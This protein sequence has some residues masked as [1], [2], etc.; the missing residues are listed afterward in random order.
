MEERADSS[1]TP[2]TRYVYSPVYIDAIITITRDSD[3]NGSLDQRL[4]VVQ[5]SNW[6]VTALLNDSGIVVERYAYD[7]YGAVTILDAAWVVK[8]GGS[9]Y[10]LRP[11]CQ[12][13]RLGDSSG[14]VRAKDREA[15]PINH[16]QNEELTLKLIRLKG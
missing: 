6:N 4:W 16:G 14:L 10:A 2:H 7:A 12:G 3:A 13:F 8:S 15:I 11:S 5:D 1:S 9:D